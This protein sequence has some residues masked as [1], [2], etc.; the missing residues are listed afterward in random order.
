MSSVT[1]W[2]VRSLLTRSQQ[3]SLIRF[4]PVSYCQP[5]QGWP[6][7]FAQTPAPKENLHRITTHKGPRFRRCIEVLGERRQACIE[8]FDASRWNPS[9]KN[10]SSYIK[11]HLRE[12]KD[13]RHINTVM[14]IRH[15]HFL[16]QKNS[17]W[18]SFATREPSAFRRA[19]T[20]GFFLRC[21]I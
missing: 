1:K 11:I 21:K 4:Y 18:V 7:R 17:G 9:E 20:L 15:T 13:V 12:S 10:F 2:W 14:N 19:N 16:P 8:R 3:C 5:N 6:G